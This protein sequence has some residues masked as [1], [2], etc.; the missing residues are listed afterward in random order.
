MLL[1]ISLREVVPTTS[2]SIQ[3]GVECAYSTIVVLITTTI[4]VLD[5]SKTTSLVLSGVLESDYVLQWKT[6]M[7][8]VPREISFVGR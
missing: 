4:V 6:H 1:G 5:H 2:N 3:I 8:C 7:G